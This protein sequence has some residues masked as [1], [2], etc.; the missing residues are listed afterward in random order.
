MGRL[1]GGLGLLL[2]LGTAAVVEGGLPWSL[3]SE[4]VPSLAPMLEK[5]TPGVVNIAAASVV[6]MTENPL[7]NDPFFKRF[8]ELPSLGRPRERVQRSLGSGVV[9]DAREGLVITNSHV[10]G[11]AEQI[12]VGL[13][14][15]RILEARKV[16]VD[17]DTD[18]AV[19]RIPGEN[20]TALSLGDSDGLRVGDFVVAIGN[21][22]GLG[23]TVTSGIVSALGRRGLGIEGYEDFIQTD[24]SINPGN[25]G[26]ALVN[27][28][29]E[30]VGINT[31][32]LAKGGGNVGI[33]FAIPVNMARRIVAQLTEYGEVRRG[34][35]GVQTQDLT[36]ELARALGFSAPEGA[37]VS[38]VVKGSAAQKGGI[39][40]EDVIVEV[41]G[42]PVPDS[43]SLRN[44]IGLVRIGEK[45]R[46]SL[47]RGGKRL[48]KEVI[49]TLPSKETVEGGRVDARL[50]GATLE[51][52]SLPPE[53]DEGILVK[54]IEPQSPAA[55][56]GLQAGDRLIAVN[57]KKVQNQT[58]LSEAIGS[59]KQGLLLQV[60]RGKEN[61]LIMLR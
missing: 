50:K 16:G 6:Q 38:G 28:R 2:A 18:V 36:P 44:A 7:F 20:L 40:V 61:L 56:L 26:G 30:L 59:V 42:R 57:R 32:I 23:Q 47:M 46:L 58:E 49:V 51:T 12:R 60:M 25:S 54:K 34:L 3:G 10:I 48:E 8:F 27:L 19:I 29:G 35:L 52:E 17:P 41:D 9:I 13:S 37:L 53:G 15:G 14:D 24:A 1:L 22:F 11:Q 45:V 31:A 21:P 39:Q 43:A 33:G 4:P 5:V 55:R